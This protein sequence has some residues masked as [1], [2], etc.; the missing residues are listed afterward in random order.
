MSKILDDF[1]PKPKTMALG[2]APNDVEMIVEA[3]F[4][5]IIKNTHGAGIPH[6]GD[7]AEASLVRTKH[8]GPTGWNIEVQARLKQLYVEEE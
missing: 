4:G 1:D 7:A 2:D 3:D 8:S 6:Q 5:V